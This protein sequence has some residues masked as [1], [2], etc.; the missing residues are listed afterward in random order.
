MFTLQRLAGNQAVSHMAAAERGRPR[1]AQAP[2]ATPTDE[3]IDGG[4][5][6]AFSLDI[7]VAR[8][9]G[10]APEPA[11]QEAPRPTLMAADAAEAGE[12][13]KEEVGPDGTAVVEEGDAIAPALAYSGAVGARATPP[14]ASLFGVTTTN[15][16]MNG[17]SVGPGAAGQ[18]KVI[19]GVDVTAKWSVHSRG[20]TDVPYYAA[21]VVT[22]DTYP[23]VA[24]D[25]KPNMSSDGGRPPRQR[26]WAKDLTERH[27]R[28]HANERTDK[29]G[30]AAF[31]FAK[32]WLAS[33]T[34][35]TEQEAN[36]L[37]NKVP[38]K[39]FESY[40]ASFVP[41]KENRAYG[42][43]AIAYQVRSDMAKT[44][45]EELKK[46]APGGK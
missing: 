23:K 8:R 24:S 16:K 31:E 32:A 44:Y 35:S 4:A 36:D 9:E 37:A 34:A 3:A 29:Y 1:P 17:L 14:D 20:R 21:P 27:E 18:F 30:K 39:M 41:G 13:P 28:F 25:L 11:A 38:D 2:Y 7:L 45:G 15:V 5:D 12:E 46:A 10:P 26:Y 19:G 6:A 22:A 33:Q 42:D 40:N 43:G